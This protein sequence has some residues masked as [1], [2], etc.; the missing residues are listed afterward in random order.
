MEQ[1]FDKAHGPFMIKT[2]SQLRIEEHKLTQ[3]RECKK[4]AQPALY[5][6]GKSWKYFQ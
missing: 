6:M 4:N 3:S 1:A 5:T 2:L